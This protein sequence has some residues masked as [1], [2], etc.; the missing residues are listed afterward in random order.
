MLKTVAFIFVSPLLG[1][2]LG[3][4]LMVA[5]AW[6]VPARLAVARGQDVPAPAAGVGGAYSWATAATM[7]KRPSA[8]SGCC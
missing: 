2:L 6:A 4:L 5:V 3:S 1:F 7:R 8:S